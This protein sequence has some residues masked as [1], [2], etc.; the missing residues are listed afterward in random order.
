MNN[1]FR[2]PVLAVVSVSGIPSI[3][4]NPVVLTQSHAPGSSFSSCSYFEKSIVPLNS[5]SVVPLGSGMHETVVSERQASK[6]AARNGNLRLF[7]N[8]CENY[9]ASSTFYCGA[10]SPES[11]CRAECL[12][13]P[14]APACGRSGL[15]FH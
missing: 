7:I 6:T 11:R 5:G 14:E 15:L 10:S 4:S 1:T 2:I 12:F 13:Q 9:L 3:V 8:S